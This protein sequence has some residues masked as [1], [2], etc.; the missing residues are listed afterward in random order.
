MKY[1]KAKRSAISF[2][3]IFW[4]GSEIR[5]SLSS[6]SPDGVAQVAL[7]CSKGLPTLFDISVEKIVPFLFSSRW[8]ATYKE[9]S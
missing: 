1:R 7:L 8:L 5:A 4:K 9:T 6:F 3:S 2:S